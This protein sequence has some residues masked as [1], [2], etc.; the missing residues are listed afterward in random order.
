VRRFAWKT[1]LYRF[2]KI[3][4]EDSD[5]DAAEYREYFE[6]VNDPKNRFRTMTVPFDGGFELSVRV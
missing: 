5:V 2:S 4:L 3:V 6:F 1:I